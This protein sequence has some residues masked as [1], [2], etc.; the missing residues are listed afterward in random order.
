MDIGFIARTIKTAAALGLLIII[1]GSYYYGF[2]A[3]LSVFTGLVWGMV[4]LYFLEKLIRSALRPDGVDKTTALVVMFIKFPLLYASGYFMVTSEYFDA[5]LLL[6]GFSVVLLVMVLKA[7][8]RTI[9]KL[10]NMDM[11]NRKESLKSV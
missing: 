7:V 4:N 3:S 6:I 1:F 10:D 2:Q 8:G 9:L 5:I 11:S